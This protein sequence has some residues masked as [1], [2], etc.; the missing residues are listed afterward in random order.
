M[1]FSS[2]QFENVGL[3][4]TE[5]Y[6]KCDVNVWL[7]SCEKEIIDPIQGVTT[8]IIPCWLKGSLIRNGP[9]SLKAGDDHF[10]H[11]FD[12]SSLLHR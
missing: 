10:D 12:S 6:P 9:G 2:L 7:R 8:G 11:L 3:Q 5:L 1:S 4:E